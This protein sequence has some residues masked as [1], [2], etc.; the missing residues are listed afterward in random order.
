MWV[1]ADALEHTSGATRGHVYDEHGD[2]V[3]LRGYRVDALTDLTDL[4]IDRLDRFDRGRPFLLFVSFLEP[5]HQNN[6]FRTIGPTGWARRFAGFDRPGDLPA[7][8]GD[9]RWN[10]A[11]YLACCA[12]IDTNLGRLV[13]HLDRDGRLESTLVVFTSDH[14]NHFRTRN[15]EYKRSPHDASIRIPLVI[16]GPGFRDGG[17]RSDLATNLDLMPTLVTAAGGDD[18]GLDGRPLQTDEGAPDAVLVQVSESQTGRALRTPTHTYAAKAPGHNPLAGHLRPAADRYAGT[19][20]YDNTRDPTNAT[21]SSTTPPPPICDAPSPPAWQSGS[22]RSRAPAPP[23]P[24]RRRRWAP[25]ARPLP[26]VDRATLE[27]LAGLGEQLEPA[28]TGATLRRHERPRSVRGE[29]DPQRV[30]AR[31]QA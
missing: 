7:W 30:E 3:D 29:V 31:A 24:D 28:S 18:P 23:S 21:T 5:H 4:A 15:L 27:D 2:R 9:W 26:L 25:W 6:R 10:Y 12:S 14:G 20:L 11:E 16:A 17:H 13:D 19:H 8:R 22:A 1:A